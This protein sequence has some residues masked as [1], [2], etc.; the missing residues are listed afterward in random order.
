MI[1]K[2]IVALAVLSFASGAVAKD[3]E[4]CLPGLICASAPAAVAKALQDAG[5]KAKLAKDDGG[6]P[7]ISSSGGGYDYDIY[8]YGCE[9]HVQCDSLQFSMTFTRDGYEDAAL[10][11]EWNVKQRFGKAHIDAKGRF[12]VEY[13]VGM[14]GGLNPKNFEDVIAWWNTTLDGMGKFWK[15][16]PNPKASGKK[17]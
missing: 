1:L 6:D 15:E 9:N 4:D 13:D 12:R 8:F 7:M 17:S 11:N 3:A 5:Y 14:I 10:A 2:S 16:H